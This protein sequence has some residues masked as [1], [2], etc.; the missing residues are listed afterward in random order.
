MSQTLKSAILEYLDSKDHSEW[1]DLTD[2]L[3]GH[4]K[5]GLDKIRS[6]LM[7]LEN[8]G[9]VEFHHGSLHKKL[10]LYDRFEGDRNSHI[11]LENV[12]QLMAKILD[13]GIEKLANSP[14]PATMIPEPKST[15]LSGLS[16]MMLREISRHS[17]EPILINRLKSSL[18]VITLPEFE[19]ALAD[20][21]HSDFIEDDPVDKVHVSEPGKK[22]LEKYDIYEIREATQGDI[23]F[24][25]L[26]FLYDLNDGIGINGFPKVFVDNVPRRYYP[27]SVQNLYHYLTLDQPICQYVD[28]P[29]DLFRINSAGKAIYESEI[30]D[31]KRNN[32]ASI[33]TFKIEHNEYHAPVT[34]YDNSGNEGIL[35][36]ESF[37][38]NAGPVST[39]HIENKTVKTGEDE[40][41]KEIHKKALT[42][43]K[44][45]RFYTIV[46][47]ALT[48]L[49]VLLTL[50]LAGC[51]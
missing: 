43:H 44:H 36:Q 25:I 17:H 22:F 5:L 24:A 47:V 49:L 1:T 32:P 31:R 42:V 14:K 8:E 38:G 18:G 41:T 20:L 46:I 11:T 3:K 9:C 10:D 21:R 34:N 33:G 37:K 27:G 51:L 13:P 4:I 6:A 45:T 40:E 29:N 15:G 50:K 28:H 48:I 7:Q 19:K 2:F 39:G 30:E 35:F 16:L 26:K 23:K 12:P